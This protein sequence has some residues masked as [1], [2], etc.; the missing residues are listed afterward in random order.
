MSGL[1]GAVEVL[2]RLV[3]FDTTSRNSNRELIA[4]AAALLGS[5]GIGSRISDVDG[6]ANLHAVIGPRGPGGIALSAHVDCVPVEGQA[7][8][9]DPF[10]L[11]RVD[12]RLIGR[13][14]CDM[15]GFAACVLAL[16]PEMAAADL[17]R[18]IHICLTHDE[19]TTFAG[20]ARL[21][22]LMAEDGPLPEACVVGEPT[23]MAPVVAHKGYASWNVTI[24]GL[25]GHS[26]RAH[27]TANALMA[28]GEAIAWLA[29][30]A[31]C[32]R[33]TGRR[34]AGFDPPWT[35]V[36]AGTLSAGTVLNIVP[37]R[38][39][40]TFEVRS[41]PG[42][43]PADVLRRLQAFM[44]AEV[45]PDLRR[46]FPAAGM[47]VS[48]RAEAP[49]LSLDADHPLALLAQRLSGRNQLGRVSYGTEAGYF[50]RAGIA[51][52]VCGPGDVAQAHLPEEWVTEA[53][54]EA[55]LGFLRRLIERQSRA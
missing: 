28:A 35:T 33:D 7:W 13:G 47:L 48:V 23:S 55:C 29:R 4:Y 8:L 49:A 1:E 38:A 20:A 17:L 32:F 6:K 44:E 2:A 21:M 11:R 45:L 9:G 52:V 10:A 51:T 31:R 50:Q 22:P 36:H 18:P 40:F 41:V 42:D 43:D 5:A 16:A 53:Q 14:A 12:G 54:M 15:K 37:D 24:L 39:D 46:V 34:A 26:S 30:E 27:E 3:A 19:E 25:S